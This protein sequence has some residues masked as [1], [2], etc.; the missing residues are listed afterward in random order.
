MTPALRPSTHTPAKLPA[1]MLGPAAWANRGA[2]SEPADPTAT[3]RRNARR[4]VSVP[5]SAS[6]SGGAAGT[7]SR[8]RRNHG[9][10][11]IVKLTAAATVG[12]PA[13]PG[14]APSSVLN[15]LEKPA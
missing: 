8:A 15:G 1:T 5:M 11:V 10:R 14:A 7:S 13:H 12:V 9:L 4:L 6:L 2:T 3:A